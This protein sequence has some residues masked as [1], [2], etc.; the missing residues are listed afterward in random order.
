MI[1][2]GQLVHVDDI[3]FPDGLLVWVQLS[4]LDLG[5]QGRLVD[6]HPVVALVLARPGDVFLHGAF[7]FIKQTDV[8]RSGV[9]QS[10][11]ILRLC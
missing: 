10:Q 5:W 7:L 2:S 8:T 9:I 3:V 11:F 4:A 1:F 6:P